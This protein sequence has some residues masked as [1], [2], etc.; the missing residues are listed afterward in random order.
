MREDLDQMVGREVTIDGIARNAAGGAVVLTDDRT[1]IY[2]AGLSRWDG[3]ID[4]KKIRA[5]GTLR[6]LAGQ[7]LV[8][9]KGEVSHGFPGERL[10][11]EQPS[12]VA[13]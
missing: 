7:D 12:W 13:T 4:G 3:A 6:K 2:V 11:L 5:T 10:V 8:N 9:A 1:P